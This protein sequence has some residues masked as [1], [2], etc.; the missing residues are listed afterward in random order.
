MS[1]KY[2]KIREQ[3]T[4]RNSNAILYDG[5]EDALVGVALRFDMQAIACYDMTKCIKILMKRDKM[6]YEEATEWFEYN[7]MGT[8]AGEFTPIFINPYE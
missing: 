6:T 8:W 1:L 3:L 7:T 5:Y 2:E 4:E